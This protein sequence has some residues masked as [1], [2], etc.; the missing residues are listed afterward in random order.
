MLCKEL[1]HCLTRLC[2]PRLKTKRQCQEIEAEI[3]HITEKVKEILSDLS[4]DASPANDGRPIH[5]RSLY[6]QCTY[7]QDVLSS[8][9]HIANWRI[10]YRRAL[11]QKEKD[12]RAGRRGD[13]E[14]L[15]ALSGAMLEVVK[16]TEAEGL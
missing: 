12:Q 9:C 11:G 3:G 13:L 4:R 8:L 15:G 2:L 10:H 16:P 5:Q 14:A 6:L 1:K 7:I